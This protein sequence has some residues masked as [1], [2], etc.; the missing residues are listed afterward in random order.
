[1]ATTVN[2]NDEQRSFVIAYNNTQQQAIANVAQ[3][4]SIQSD[5]FIFFAAFDGTN[6]NKANPALSGDPQQTNI[7]EL[8]DQVNGANDSETS[9]V[10]IGYFPGPLQGFLKPSTWSNSAVTAQI[11]SIAED[12]YREFAVDAAAWLSKSG[13]SGKSVSVALAGFSR[14]C[15]TAAVFSQLLYARGLVTETGTTLIPPGQVSIV[16]GVLFDPV[17]TGVNG[18]LAFSPNARN[19]VD[20]TAV[21]EYR[22]QFRSVEYSSQSSAI[23]VFGM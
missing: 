11:V 21:N 8:I 16:A 19:I 12:A 2:L 14:G 9:N 23:S 3:A 10:G 13:N 18:N 4:G 20:I 17:Y 5:Q 7:G 15:A 6:N 1:M 22:T